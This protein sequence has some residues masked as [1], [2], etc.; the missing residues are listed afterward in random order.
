MLMVNEKY[1]N[2]LRQRNTAQSVTHAFIRKSRVAPTEAEQLL[3]YVTRKRQV[4]GVADFLERLTGKYEE[5]WEKIGG[6][7]CF[8]SFEEY[9]SFA[10]GRLMMTFIRSNNF[11]EIGSVS[12]YFGDALRFWAALDA[13]FCP[14]KVCKRRF[15]TEATVKKADLKSQPLTHT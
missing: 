10:H 15:L 1:W 6:E 12:K 2:R 7:S 14:L 3:F 9:K 13:N 8:E 4:L 11:R 5:L